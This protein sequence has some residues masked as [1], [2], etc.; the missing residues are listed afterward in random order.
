MA[1]Y[2]RHRTFHSPVG[3]NLVWLHNKEKLKQHKYH[4]DKK[5]HLQKLFS[6]FKLI[7]PFEQNGVDFLDSLILLEIYYVVHDTPFNGL[8]YQNQVGQLIY[9]FVAY[10]LWIQKHPRRA[11]AQR[12]IFIT[13]C[14][15]CRENK[16]L[17]ELFI[18]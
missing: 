15:E 7:F 12:S 17:L 6:P 14:L 9:N 2:K 1:N 3:I 13:K 8:D 11:H 10:G 18:W 5:R 4:H 16:G